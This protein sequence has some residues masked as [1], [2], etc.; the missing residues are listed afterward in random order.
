MNKTIIDPW[1]HLTCS[2]SISTT[3]CCIQRISDY[4]KKDGPEVIEIELLLIEIEVQTPEKRLPIHKLC[5]TG[6]VRRNWNYPGV[7]N[8]NGTTALCVRHR[9]DMEKSTHGH[10]NLL[11]ELHRGQR[12]CTEKLNGQLLI[13]IITIKLGRPEIHLRQLTKEK[14]Q[15]HK[16]KEKLLLLASRGTS[17]TLTDRVSQ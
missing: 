3:H 2:N 15:N 14:S 1:L 13:T 6:S 17:T 12:L 9:V 11:R 10:K 7:E 16:I 5:R 8:I 4:A